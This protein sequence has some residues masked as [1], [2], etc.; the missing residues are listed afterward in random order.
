[1]SNQ[2]SELVSNLLDEKP[3]GVQEVDQPEEDSNV[4]TEELAKEAGLSNT[5]IGKPITE[6]AKAYK[7]A[8]KQ[9]TVKSQETAE[10]RRRLEQLESNISSKAQTQKEETQVE[11]AFENIPDPIEYPEE[12]QKWA[13]GLVKTVSNLKN[14]SSKDLEEVKTFTER[15]KDQQILGSIQSG[16]PEG[17]SA[18]EVLKEWAALGYITNTSDLQFWRNKP[19]AFAE[20]VISYYK[21]KHTQEMEK[22]RSQKLGD[23]ELAKTKTSLQTKKKNASELNST[24][25]HESKPEGIVATLLDMA[26]D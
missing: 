6:L 8:N 15:Q 14:V 7:E 13:K 10:F 3:K 12:F 23:A 9:F 4:I 2:D 21:L 18:D 17:V 1:M 11:D 25:R 5:F 16:L 26:Q 20:N 24:A 19:K 22:E